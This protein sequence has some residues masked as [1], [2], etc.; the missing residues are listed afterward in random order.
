MTDAEKIAELRREVERLRALPPEYPLSTFFTASEGA[1]MCEEYADRLEA[2]T[3]GDE[4]DETP[5]EAAA[6]AKVAKEAIE[7]LQRTGAKSLSELIGEVEEE[8][9]DDWRSGMN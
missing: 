2:G 1:D 9:G 7:L 4:D 5:E 8:K 6:A 3:L